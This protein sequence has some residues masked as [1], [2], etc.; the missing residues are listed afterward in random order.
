MKIRARKLYAVA[1]SAAAESIR[2]GFSNIK[3]EKDRV[4]GTDGRRI[5]IVEADEITSYDTE[6]MINALQVKMWLRS[7]G[8]TRKKN[9]DSMIKTWKGDNCAVL[10]LTNKDGVTSKKFEI[11]ENSDYPE[12][13]KIMP[14]F[15]FTEKNASAFDPQYIKDI[16]EQALLLNNENDITLGIAFKDNET[17]AYFS[18]TG[19]VT[20]LMPLERDTPDK[21]ILDKLVGR[22]QVGK[23]EAAK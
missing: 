13:P 8:I 16:A 17:G 7:L 15:A 6:Y 12:W 20:L 4:V 10:E 9:V 22:N 2:Y 21:A 23:E 5:T 1:M 11:D 14:D 18:F 3:F 19:G